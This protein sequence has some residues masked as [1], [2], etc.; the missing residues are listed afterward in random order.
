MKN[1]FVLA[2]PLC[3]LHYSSVFIFRENKMLINSG[4]ETFIMVDM[5]DDRLRRVRVIPCQ[6][7]IGQFAES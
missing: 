3:K 5:T 2:S 4:Q 7:P 1:L 6:S